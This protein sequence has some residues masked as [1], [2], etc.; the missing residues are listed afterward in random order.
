[1]PIDATVLIMAVDKSHEATNNAMKHH[2]YGLVDVFPIGQLQKQGY[3][4]YTIDVTGIPVDTLDDA[5]YLILPPVYAEPLNVLANED[6][7]EIIHRRRF[8]LDM[9]IATVDELN[10]LAEQ[11]H[12]D[13][14]WARVF[15]LFKDVTSG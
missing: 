11:R 2:K 7:P 9:G 4:F 3:S 1:M 14:S 8:V 12:L 6:D 10:G 5:K 13:L 15:E